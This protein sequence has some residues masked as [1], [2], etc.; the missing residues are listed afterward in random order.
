MKKKKKKEEQTGLDFNQN[1]QAANLESADSTEA[2][3]LSLTLS[4][5]FLVVLVRFVF[6]WVDTF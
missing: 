2:C 4:A 5:R 3:R 6:N 1:L